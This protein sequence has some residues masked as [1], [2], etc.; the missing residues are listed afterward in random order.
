MARG[1]RAIVE[2]DGKEGALL[3]AD[4]LF[5]EWAHN[6][7]PL[8]GRSARIECEEEGIYRFGELT[9]RSGSVADIVATK[10]RETSEDKHY[11]RQLLEM[12]ERTGDGHQQWTTRIFAMHATKESNYQDVVW[13]EVTPPRDFE[14]DAKPPRLVRDLISEGHCNDRGSRCRNLFNPSPTTVRSRS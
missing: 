14:G 5:H 8:E 3:T 13:I 2:L 1:Y 11:E 7:Y 4:R 10:L 12:V 9:S 6:K